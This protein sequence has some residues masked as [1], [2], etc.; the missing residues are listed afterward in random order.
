MLEVSRSNCKEIKPVNPKGN[1]F[2]IFI[3]RID[4]EAPI[5]WPP[6]VK[7]WLIVKDPDAG[8]DWRQKEKWV[9]REETVGWHHWLNG[10]EFEQTL[11]D[12]G[13]QTWCAA[14]YGV[15]KSQTWL[16]DWTMTTTIGNINFRNKT[17]H[18]QPPWV[19]RTF[20][21]LINM[22]KNEK[23]YDIQVWGRE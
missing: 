20:F 15:A 22:M 18:I 1:Q 6:G 16:R 14:V 12:S 23:R 17:F 10:H 2:W 7:S 4:A 21:D 3:G 19:L 13:G 11:G 8:K 5:L 9:A